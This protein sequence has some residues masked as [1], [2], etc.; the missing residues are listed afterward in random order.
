MKYLL[1]LFILFTVTSETSA[2]QK[3]WK[4]SQLRGPNFGS[5]NHTLL[6]DKNGGI[7]AVGSMG[8][9]HS[10]NNGNTWDYHLVIN[11]KPAQCYGQYFGSPYHEKY[12]GLFI[13]STGEY[14]FFT[15]SC[16]NSDTNIAGVYRST[17]Q[18]ITW[19]QVLKGYHILQM[20]KG[21]DN[22][23]LLYA[24]SIDQQK[25]YLFESIDQ[26]S[27]WTELYK[28]PDYRFL[29]AGYNNN[30]LFAM[31][32][33]GEDGSGFL[34]RMSFTNHLW[35]DYCPKGNNFPCFSQVDS[36]LLMASYGNNIYTS[37]G[38][39]KWDSVGRLS[40]VRAFIKGTGDTIYAALEVTDQNKL[41]IFFTT[42]RGKNWYNYAK[43]LPYTYNNF[44]WVLNC[45]NSH[46]LLFENDTAL[47]LSTDR[48]NSWKE[49]G[50]P[51]DSIDNIIVS[52]TEG[53]LPKWHHIPN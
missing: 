28:P 2:Q 25:Y 26:G 30:Y 12:S 7:I 1:V 15:R 31:F 50:L 8:Y 29:V 27:S 16:D 19:K 24:S 52:E 9:Y 42:D 10:L 43:V 13:S 33:P 44:P 6:D 22:S 20:V 51:S 34:R 32:Y 49:I 11:G 14:F 53:F 23:L 3:P 4:W 47:Y 36:N 39:N 46:R 41:F 37:D 17:D 40:G 35:E 5:G 18:G 45:K 38:E 21:R 48:G